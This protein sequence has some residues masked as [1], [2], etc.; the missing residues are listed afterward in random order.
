M[1]GKIKPALLLAV[2]VAS[3]YPALA[4][5][6]NTV[7]TQNIY[8]IN[9]QISTVT[10]G[11][12]QLTNI[13]PKGCTN[14]ISEI[15][16]AQPSSSPN[17]PASTNTHAPAPANKV[18]NGPSNQLQPELPFSKIASGSNVSSSSK[19]SSFNSNIVKGVLSGA[20]ALI[21]LVVLFIFVF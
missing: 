13:S 12:G 16:G 11:T 1:T 14:I 4:T 20:A 17:K 6:E 21:L 3:S 18:I 8:P 19:N 5:A 9:C 7:F 2:A 15:T 10:V